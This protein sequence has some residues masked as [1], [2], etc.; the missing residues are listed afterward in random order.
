MRDNGIDEESILRHLLCECVQDPNGLYKQDNLDECVIDSADKEDFSGCLL[1]KII[2]MNETT[3]HLREYCEGFS[4]GTILRYLD[5]PINPRVII[6]LEAFQA[7]QD[8]SMPFG[9]CLSNN[10]FLLPAKY[11]TMLREIRSKV[12][13]PNY[14]L[15]KRKRKRKIKTPKPLP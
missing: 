5:I 4:I 10:E 14:L 15:F 1:S 12:T 13:E 9:E 7:D 2:F 6:F 3:Q 11:R 8:C